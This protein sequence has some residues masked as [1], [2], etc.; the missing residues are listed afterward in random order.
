MY[1]NWIN[2]NFKF[3]SF[4]FGFPINEVWSGLL[5]QPRLA[6]VLCKL[7]SSYMQAEMYTSTDSRRCKTDEFYLQILNIDTV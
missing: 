6:H 7:V 5:L 2:V 3:V 4:R 1:L